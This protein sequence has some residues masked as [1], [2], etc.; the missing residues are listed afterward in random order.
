MVNLLKANYIGALHQHSTIDSTFSFRVHEL[1][2]NSRL[3]FWNLLIPAGKPVTQV[4][5]KKF[6][7][8]FAMV[9]E[10]F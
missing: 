3:F 1:C 2:Q 7:K 5:C 10:I 9:S 8:I 4:G 6:L